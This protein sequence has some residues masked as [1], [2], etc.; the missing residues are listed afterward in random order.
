MS[1]W[2]FIRPRFEEVTEITFEEAQDAIDYLDSKGEV[3]IDLAVQNAVREKVEAVLKE[4]PDANVAHYDH[5]NETSWIGNDERAVVDLENVDLLT[6]RECYCNNCSSAKTLGVEAW[7]RKAKAYWGYKDIFYFTTD[8][9]EEFQEFVNNGIKRRVDSYTW[10]DCLQ[11]TKELATKL[12]DKLVQT[13]RAMAAACMT[14]DRDCLVCYTEDMPPTSDCAFRKLGIKLFGPKAGWK[15]S[16]A[17]PISVATFFLGLGILLHDYCH[18]L[19]QV[20]GYKEILSLQGGY[21][22]AAML[23]VGFLLA[24]YQIWSFMKEKGGF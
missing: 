24:Y 12:I 10:K 14:H 11:M 2:I 5:G 6:G 17:F 22:G 19:W 13:G 9:K 8:A 20:G 18:A 3:T 23:I 4:N 21:F 7:K 1:K 15:L 16:K